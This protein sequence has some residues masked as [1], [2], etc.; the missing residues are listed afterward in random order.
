MLSQCEQTTAHRS[1]LAGHSFLHNLCAKNGFYIFRITEKIK[2]IILEEFNSIKNTYLE[3]PLE[4]LSKDIDLVEKET[5][6][7]IVDDIKK[8]NK[9]KKEKEE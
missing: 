8:G 3:K 6:N 7:N 5:N 4:S 9:P 2:R 1:N